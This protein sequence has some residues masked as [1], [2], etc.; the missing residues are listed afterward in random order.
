[1]ST[2]SRKL[3]NQRAVQRDKLNRNLNKQYEVKRLTN[4]SLS[5]FRLRILLAEVTSYLMKM[6]KSIKVQYSELTLDIS[7]KEMFNFR[8]LKNE[9]GMVK[10]F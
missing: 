8:D 5:Q 1:M 10:I 4:L 2:C 7:I 6:S 9:E 3:R